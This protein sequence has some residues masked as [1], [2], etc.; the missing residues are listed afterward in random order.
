MSDKDMLSDLLNEAESFLNQK[1]TY[2]DNN[3]RAWN[4]Q[5]KRV[6]EKIYGK[7]SRTSTMFNNR[8]YSVGIYCDE[9]EVEEEIEA[10]ENGLKQTICD[11]KRLIKEYDYEFKDKEKSSNKT[12]SE[13]N[14]PTISINVDASSNNR[15]SN[16]NTNN[17]SIKSYKEVREEIDNN[18]YL[19]D[20]SKKELLEKLEEIEELEKSKDNKSKKWAVGKKIL[21]FIIDKGADIAIMYIPLIIQAISK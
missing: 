15:I 1:L 20:N 13:K 6:C 2:D 19:D 18:T 8:M 21:E 3:V 17:I 5:L 10:L 14:K 12:K 9:L 4:N 11:L 7:G 16:N